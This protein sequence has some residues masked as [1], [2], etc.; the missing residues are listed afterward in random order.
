M[1]AGSRSASAIVRG[2]PKLSGAQVMCSDL[3]ASAALVI[4]GLVAEG[5]TRLL[6]VYHID[7]GYEDVIAKLAGLGAQVERV[8]GEA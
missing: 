8:R 6:R 2:V 1:G 7:R 3:R 5:E 4:A